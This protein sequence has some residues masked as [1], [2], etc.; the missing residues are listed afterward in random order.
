MF[1]NELFIKICVASFPP[2]IIMLGIVF[3]KLLKE[4]QKNSEHNRVN[5]NLIK[6]INVRGEKIAE[7]GGIIGSMRKDNRKLIADREDLN[8]KVNEFVE[9]HFPAA[10]TCDYDVM[11]FN[12]DNGI[13]KAQSIGKAEN[14]APGEAEEI[15]C[16]KCGAELEG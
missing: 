7:L 3:G 15:K 12:T 4:I 5:E 10:V 2:G 9:K 13:L 11:V 1:E 14:H 8:K 16:P 6:S